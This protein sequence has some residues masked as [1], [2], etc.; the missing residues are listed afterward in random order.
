[1]NRN[2]ELHC[3]REAGRRYF[4]KAEHGYSNSL[5]VLF[6]GKKIFQEINDSEENLPIT[7]MG[8]LNFDESENLLEFKY[9]IKFDGLGEERTDVVFAFNADEC[10]ATFTRHNWVK[11]SEKLA[12][13]Y[14]VT[15]SFNGQD[16]AFGREWHDGDKKQIQFLRRFDLDAPLT[17]GWQ[18]RKSF[19]DNSPPL[20]YDDIRIRI[21][22]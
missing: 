10:R 20:T 1:M 5:D 4:S 15:F 11:G 9:D 18:S 21:W 19:V 14:A 12:D 13:D 6:N 7:M 16:E 17:F 8:Q 2:I 3:P 22:N